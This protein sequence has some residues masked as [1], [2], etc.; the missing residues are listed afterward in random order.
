MTVAAVLLDIDGVLTQSWRPLAGGAAAV[1]WLREE[2]I[3]FRLLTNTTSRSR[4]AVAEAVRSADIPVADEDVV[5]AL[6]ATARYLRSNHPGA[7]CMVLND[8]D[9]GEDLSDIDLVTDNPEVVIFGTA[10]PSFT[11]ESLN[12]AFRAALGGAT[13]LAMHRNLYWR[14]DEGMRLDGGAFLAGLERAAGVEAMVVGKPAPAF[15]EAALDPLGAPVQQVAMV[16]DDIDNDVL[17]AQALGM[18]GI[19]VR[20]GKYRQEAVDAAPASPDLIVDSIADLPSALGGLRQ[21]RAQG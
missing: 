21:R 18:L 12:A 8:G 7:R 13:L 17:A 5:T 4:H 2:R 15:F 6:V 9:V 1:A 10:G 20:T 19:L 11:Y 14:T 3:P 16:G